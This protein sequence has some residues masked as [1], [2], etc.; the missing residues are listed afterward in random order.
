ME[1]KAKPRGGRQNN[2]NNKNKTDDAYGRPDTARGG[3]KEGRGGRG[4]RGGADRKPREVTDEERKGGDR[5]ENTR[6]GKRDD[7]DRRDNKDGDKKP[8]RGPA[9][10]EN[11]W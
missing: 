10:D 11:S 5:R 6:G 4:G 7:R 3:R 8:F 2:D 9:L 1:Y